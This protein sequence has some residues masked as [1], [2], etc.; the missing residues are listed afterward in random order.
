MRKTFRITE[1]QLNRIVSESIKKI[2]SEEVDLGWNHKTQY[3]KDEESRRRE[4][5]RKLNAPIEKEIH[6]LRNE[7]DEHYDD[8]EYCEKLGRQIRALKSKLKH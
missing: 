8:D 6:R 7:I 1:S 4:A 5:L 2:I 3:E